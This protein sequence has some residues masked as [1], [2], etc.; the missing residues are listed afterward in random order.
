ML[1]DRWEKCGFRELPKRQIGLEHLL[2]A[3]LF[4]LCALI[5]I[6]SQY[7]HTAN[8]DE[9]RIRIV[10][11]DQPP[12]TAV[13]RLNMAGHDRL[14]MCTGVL[15]GPKTVITAAHCLF[16]GRSGYPHPVNDLR[17]VTGVRRDQN[18]GV[19][20]VDC[21][22][23]LPGFTYARKP[24]VRDTRWDIAAVILKHPLPVLPV[25]VIRT[26]ALARVGGETRLRA[27]GY[28]RSRKFLPTLDGDCR[29]LWTRDGIWITSCA[30][31]SG[32]SGGPVFV[33]DDGIWKLAAIMSAR[34]NRAG[35]IAVPRGI[36]SDLVRSDAC[37]GP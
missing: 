36:W 33:E 25:P 2:P 34:L 35:S 20:E 3:L 1:T 16:D 14:S 17:F 12:W 37:P 13:G 30:T 7:P 10:D 4:L 15:V 19:A 27:A 9:A 21:A 8:A 29:L 11:S 26:S 32:A 5:L 31:E 23:F 24:S 22:L 6:F 28:R 18:A